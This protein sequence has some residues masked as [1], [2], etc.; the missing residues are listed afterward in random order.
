MCYNEAWVVRKYCAS[1]TKVSSAWSAQV[2]DIEDACLPFLWYLSFFN[3]K[4]KLIIIAKLAHDFPVEYLFPF[5]VVIKI[6]RLA[7]LFYELFFFRPV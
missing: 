7:Q 4:S 5:R 1:G 3:M 6:Q 2:K